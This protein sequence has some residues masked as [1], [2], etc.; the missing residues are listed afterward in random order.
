MPRVTLFTDAADRGTLYP[1]L[2][3]VLASPPPD[4]EARV[5]WHGHI[6]AESH[7]DLARWVPTAA[8][9]ELLE[10]ETARVAS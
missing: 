10:R 8:G 6:L 3:A 4:P 9:L 2:S 1:S 5:T 7:P